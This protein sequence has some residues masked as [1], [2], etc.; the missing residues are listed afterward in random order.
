MYYEIHRLHRENQSVLQISRKLN[1]NRRTVRKYLNMSE[2]DYENF[3]LAQTD[4]K[5]ILLPFESFIKER[6]QLYQ[7]TSAAQMHDWLKEK[8]AENFPDVSQKTVFNFVHRVREK[9]NLPIVKPER[10]HH[11]VQELPYGKQ[12]QVDF[13]QYN[14]RTSKGTRTKVFFFTFVLSRSRF[15]FIWFTDRNFNT[16]LAIQAHNLAFEYIGGVPEEIV[17]DQD[18]VFIVSENGGNIIL[19]EGFRNY[20]RNNAFSLHFCRK[21]DPQS[22]GKVE[23]VVKYV[24]QN[25]LYNRTFYNIETLNDEALGWLGRTANIL[26]HAFTGKDPYSELTIEQPFLKAFI[27]YVAQSFSPA[28]NYAVRKD[29]S[30]SFKGNLYSLPFGTYKGRETTVSVRIEANT[31]IVYNEKADLEICRHNI[32]TGKGLKI[33]NTDHKRDKSASIQEMIN[34]ICN[35]SKDPENTHKWLEAIRTEKPRYIRDQLLIVKQ[36]MEKTSDNEL[37][38]KGVNY[39]FQ[40]QIHNAKDFESLIMHYLQQDNPTDSGTKT[41]RLNPLNGLST[42]ALH[43]QP[44]KSSIEDYQEILSKK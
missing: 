17:Y 40:N 22:K 38:Q 39:C 4:R 6:L 43:S 16:E 10:Q 3:L 24:K 15:K 25:F 5:K 37:L 27:P 41:I 8:F 7:D 29:N 14:M 20:T 26:P 28:L 21:A 18:K 30:I 32:A 13:G 19:T 36:T 11:P 2:P 42:E 12:A 34:Q 35:G 23:N 44:N 33:L 9:Y 1:I 31:L